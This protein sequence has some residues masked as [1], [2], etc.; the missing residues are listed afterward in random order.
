MSAIVTPQLRALF[1]GRCFPIAPSLDSPSTVY[2]KNTVT[3]PPP[4]TPG[5]RMISSFTPRP[6]NKVGATAEWLTTFH[7]LLIR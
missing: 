7:S 1:P 4:T 3:F 2:P 5:S 6:I